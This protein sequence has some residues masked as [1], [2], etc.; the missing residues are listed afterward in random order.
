MSE[1]ECMPS[2]QVFKCTQIQCQHTMLAAVMLQHQLKLKLMGFT[3][4]SGV[5]GLSLSVCPLS[6]AGL[7]HIPDLWQRVIHPNSHLK[8]LHTCS[9]V[10]LVHSNRRVWST[11]GH[12]GS[13][14]HLLLTAEC[15]RHIQQS[16]EQP[17]VWVPEQ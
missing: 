14:Q 4:Q 16:A 5:L 1:Q 7:R 2:L 13:S 17:R 10:K 11:D 8:C 3:S 9:S 12:C 15:L 6:G